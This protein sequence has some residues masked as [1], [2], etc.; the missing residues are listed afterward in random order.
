MPETRRQ[1][2]ERMV[3]RAA[4]RALEDA[5]EH[6]EAAREIIRRE[7]DAELAVNGLA[8]RCKGWGQQI[9]GLIAGME[10][11]IRD[12]GKKLPDQ[13]V[14]RMPA[15]ADPEAEAAE[16]AMRKIAGNA[17]GANP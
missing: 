15:V 12:L 6:V 3:R 16:R 11:E 8:S 7:R 9:D 4:Q 17:T 13:G 2:A 14:I 1:I 10:E 5:L